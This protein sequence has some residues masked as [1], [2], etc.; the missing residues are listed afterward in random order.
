MLAAVAGGPLMS[1][2]GAVAS[3]ARAAAAILHALLPEEAIAAARPPQEQRHTVHLVI[4][5]PVRKC[6]DLMEEVITP[7]GRRREQNKPCFQLRGL[8]DHALPFADVRPMCLKLVHAL[9]SQ[10]LKERRS[11]GGILDQD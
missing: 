4:I 5:A 3:P 8:R 11:R 1:M 9:A 7:F 2:P 10:L 6:P